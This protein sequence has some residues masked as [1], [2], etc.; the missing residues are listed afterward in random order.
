MTTD[1]VPLDIVPWKRLH[2]STIIVKYLWYWTFYENKMVSHHIWCATEL[3]LLNPPFNL[4]ISIRHLMTCH[5]INIHDRITTFLNNCLL[6]IFDHNFFGKKWCDLHG[7][8]EHFQESHMV[9][10]SKRTS[11]IHFHLPRDK[12]QWQYGNFI[13]H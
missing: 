13:F 5:V 12:Y 8:C 11:P 6:I 2:F 10:E 1:T 9:W 7:S 4:N 3:R